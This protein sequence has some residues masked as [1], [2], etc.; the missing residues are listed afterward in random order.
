MGMWVRPPPPAPFPR[1]PIP[2]KLTHAPRR[3]G[4]PAPIPVTLEP[5]SARQVRILWKTAAVLLLALCGW[6]YFAGN[7][8]PQFS[9]LAALSDFTH[10]YA[11]GKAVLAGRSPFGDTEYLYPAMLAFLVAPLALLDYPS[12]RLIWLLLSQVF[13]L[14]SAWLLWRFLGR[15]WLAAVCIAAIWA[16]GGAAEE[17]LSLGQV[18]ALLTLVYTV[19]IVSRRRAGDAAGLGFALKYLPGLVALPLALN[20]DWRAL[21]RSAAIGLALLIVPWLV[22]WAAFPGPST[23]VSG[24]YVVGTPA[25]L[26]WSLPGV[27]L[28]VSDPPQQGGQMPYNWEF[29]NMGGTLRL[30]TGRRLLSAGAAAFTLAAGLACFVLATK[31]RLNSPQV[32]WAIAALISL[33][34]AASPVCW[35]HYQIIQ[36]PGAAMLLTYVIRRRRLTMALVALPCLALLYPAPV[37][38]LRAYFGAHGLTAFSPGTLYL[39]TSVAP[40]ASLALFGIYLRLAVAGAACDAENAAPQL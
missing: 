24:A 6:F 31:G 26:N 28:R 5:M 8:L 1:K 17:S 11:A 23:P 20:R 19:A 7:V 10:Y 35:S 9:S 40:L 16:F 21:R 33:S 12:A 25:F 14:G 3:I 2:S 36:Y 27:A 39:W 32:P 37:A 15:G 38:A 13:L 4:A 22:V 34:L 29:G 18:G 30:D